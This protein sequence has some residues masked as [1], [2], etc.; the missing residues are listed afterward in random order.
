MAKRAA[1]DTPL[2]RQ[3]LEIKAQ[4]PGAILFFRLGDFYEMFFDDAIVAAKALDLTLTSRDKNRENPT[5]M[6]GVPH[7]AG[8][9]YLRRLIEQGFKVA[10]C[11][12][13]EDPKL[14]KGVVKREVTEVITPGVVVDAEQL[15]AKRNNYLVAVS[16]DVRQQLYGIAGLDLSTFELRV[17]ETAG[18]GAAIDELARLEARETVY[19]ARQEQSLAGLV[20]AFNRPW[21][22]L[23]GDLA[24]PDNQLRRFVGDKAE[25]ALAE[26]GLAERP[27]AVRAAGLALAYAE[28]T[29]PS[30]G[31]PR[32]R[33]QFY[34]PGDFLRLDEATLRN[35]EIFESSS[36]GR[37]AGSLLGVLD[38]TCTAMGGR[39]LRRYLGMPLLDTGAIRRRLDAVQLLV[40]QG[41][42]R[43]EL[44]QALG[45]VYDLERLTARTVLG[46]VTP[47]ELGRLGQS[48][49]GVPSVYKLLDR[50]QRA[51]LGGQLPA[52]LVP[53]GDRL[54]DVAGQIEAVL[55][56]EPPPHT[57]EGR[58]FRRGAFPELDELVDLSEG[59][60]ERIVAMERQLRARTGISS[61]K[62]RYNKVFGYFIEVT[63]ANLGAVPAD[64]ERKQ[65]LVNAE[66]F[67]TE[68]LAVHEAQVL[69]AEE[70]RIALEQQLF[71]RLRES[72]AVHAPR[73]TACAEGLAALDVF[74]SLAECAAKFSYVRPTVDDSRAIEIR[75]GRHPVVE[76]FLGAGQFVPNDLRLDEE[77]QL[78]VLTGPNMSGK[79][80]IMRQTALIA[81]M[82]QVGAFV[83]ASS[84]RIGRVD[85]IFT[86]VGAS[87]NLARGEST[88]MVEMRETSKILAEA[89]ARSLVVLDE[90]GR[91][92][93]TYD[94]ISIAWS[95]AE[96]LHDRIQARA[97]FATHYH[98]LCQLAEVKERA[99][100]YSVAVQEWQGR[101]VFLRKLVPGGASRSYGIEVARLAELPAA[102]IER[103]KQVLGALEEGRQVEGVPLRAHSL[104]QTNQ[105]PL[106][107]A[108]PTAS[109]D[110]PEVSSGLASSSTGADAAHWQQVENLRQQ[111]VE[112]ELAAA[113]AVLEAIAATEIDSLS[114]LAALNRLADYVQQATCWRGSTTASRAAMGHTRSA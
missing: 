106:F 57:R 16:L 47:R 83:P 43:E 72:L 67:V 2:M 9:N 74:A 114:P 66:R 48:L 59:G 23:R 107:G 1:T 22:P 78:V 65:T 113:V 33:V 109:V 24:L 30:R 49:A 73:L 85:R 60:K 4:Y 42:V 40:E 7:H 62:V 94:G 111:R 54:D 3:Y 56:D 99:R 93:S 102:V 69:G 88:F 76:R 15:D 29:Q 101:V 100:N 17:T 35:L 71:E 27:Q 58:I 84:A 110:R 95:V 20:A 31:V 13:V 50:A 108:R 87:D 112:A 77:Q 105:L 52:L 64:F 75:D 96:D 103:A 18:A 14:A 6:C 12:Q 37:K 44:Q 11:E 80:T 104:L 25:S 55:V 98:E 21:Q 32:C 63:K 10:I 19:D 34:L 90:I 86:R 8:R 39:L 68:E 82:A 89:T 79:S 45:G 26:L 53:P 46:M 5:P 81:L 61:L 36:D 70:R 92:T 51:T 28:S 97:L 91:G 38:S 41:S